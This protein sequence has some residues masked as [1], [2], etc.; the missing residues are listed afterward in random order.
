MNDKCALI[1]FGLNPLTVKP[2]KLSLYQ[3]A[4]RQLSAVKPDKREEA[5][6]QAPRPGGPGPDHPQ[7]DPASTETHF[8]Q[9]AA[10]YP[11]RLHLPA[12]RNHYCLITIGESQ[13]FGRYYFSE[14]YSVSGL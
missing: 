7:A 4:T 6:G 13:I 2:A 5:R 1:T 12:F 10:A 8:L 9:A 11:L 14:M 3:K